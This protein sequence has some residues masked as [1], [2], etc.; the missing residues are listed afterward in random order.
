MSKK[1][2]NIVEAWFRLEREKLTKHNQDKMVAKCGK[3]GTG[4]SYSTITEG[5]RIR[6]D[7]F[8]IKKHFAYFH[9]WAFMKIVKRSKPGDFICFDDAGV[10]LD[11]RDWQKKSN[12]LIVNLLQ[13]MR[14]KNLWVTF[15]VPDFGFIDVK[16]RKLF[17]MFCHMQKRRAYDLKNNLTRGRWYSIESDAWSGDLWRRTLRVPHQNTSYE[18]AEI[19]YEKPHK[20]VCK[21]YETYRARALDLQF[22]KADEVA[23][24]IDGAVPIEQAAKL[25]QMTSSRDLYALIRNGAIPVSREATS[26]KIPMVWIKKAGK[27]LNLKNVKDTV[28]AVHTSEVSGSL[29]TTGIY[30]LT[31]DWILA[32]LATPEPL[33]T[34]EEILPKAKIELKQAGK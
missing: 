4:K 7:D 10:G 23:E 28:V 19:S 32:Q 13:T 9:P 16:S 6:G 12:K 15:T 24:G 29:D 5:E 31:D 18:I 33:Q 3:K 11:N 2:N 25:L 34:L 30:K 26:L 14:T 27:L 22:N 21:N 1:S 20:D 17:D 8:D